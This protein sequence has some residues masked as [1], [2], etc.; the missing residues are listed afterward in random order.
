LKPNLIVEWI[1]F[2]NLQNIKYLTKGGCSDIYTADWIG[3][4]YEEWDSKEKQLKR[5]E[6]HVVVLK[7]LENVESA[8]KSWFDEGI[9]HLQLSSKSSG[10]I[11]RC[12][13]LTQNPFN[14]NYMLVIDGRDTNLRV[15][16]QQNHNQLTWK[17]RIQ[18]INNIILAVL[19]IH[20]ENAIHRDLHSGNILFSQ[21]NQRFFVSDLGFCGPANKPLDSIYGN[22]SY[23]APE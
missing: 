12:Y 1:P 11:V 10:L 4:H 8:N 18:I 17:E 7:T 2:N 21:K 20:K 16:L 23:I 5:S 22:L 9:S 15:F 6:W 3:G 19:F 14:G 13:G